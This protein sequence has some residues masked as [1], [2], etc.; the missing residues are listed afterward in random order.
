VAAPLLWWLCWN[1]RHRLACR[2]LFAAGPDDAYRINCV[3]HPGDLGDCGPLE[4]VSFEPH[5]FPALLSGWLSGR[6]IAVSAMVMVGAAAVL[7]A[8]A[9]AVGLATEYAYVP[10]YF[11]AG[12]GIAVYASTW[13]W[14]TY[15]RVVPGRL[16]VMQFSS[17]RGRPPALHRYSLR[18]ARILT[19]MRRWAVI[20]DE[21][22]R[23]VELPILLM[24]ERRRFVHAVLLAATSTHDPAPLPPDSL[25]G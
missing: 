1:V 5:I 9:S 3:G 21:G 7:Y 14:P 17:M 22:K 24:R 25:L 13:L 8:L 6:A 20:V 16:E 11:W 15:V 12:M 10:F 18:S 4:D 2:S 19:D 23:S